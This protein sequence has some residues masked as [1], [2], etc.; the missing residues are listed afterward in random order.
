MIHDLYDLKLDLWIIITDMSIIIIIK[1]Q[2]PY[3]IYI[4]YVYKVISD[5]LNFFNLSKWNDGTD[6]NLFHYEKNLPSLSFKHW[7]VNTQDFSILINQSDCFVDTWP[8]KRMLLCLSCIV[9]LIVRKK[10]FVRCRVI[11]RIQSSQFCLR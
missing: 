11:S 7:A 4:L 1:S 5:G 6:C 9:S 8:L 10:L 2:K 3:I